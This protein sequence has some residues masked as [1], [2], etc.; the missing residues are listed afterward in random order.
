MKHYGKAT[1]A[2]QK[3][4][5]ADL[6]KIG[7]QVLDLSGTGE[8]C[9]DLLTTFNHTCVL[10][11]I[12]TEEKDVDFKRGQLETFATWTN[13]IGFARN[14]DE[15]EKV[16]K[17]PSQFALSGTEKLKLREWLIR[18]PKQ[19]TLAVNKFLKIIGRMER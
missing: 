5:I 12:K 2:N 4:I 6:R 10:L 3:Q 1:D 15:A 9:P 13:Y 8:G 11:E 17:Q 14:F 19:E 7:V 18:N 16:C